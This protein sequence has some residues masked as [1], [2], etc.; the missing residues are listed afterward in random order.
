MENIKNKEPLLSLKKPFIKFSKIVLY[1]NKLLNKKYFVSKS[2]YD[3]FIIKNLIYDERNKVVSTFKEHLI[4]NDTSEFLRRYYSHKESLIRLK[5]YYE[6]YSKYSKLFPNYI[7]LSESKYIYK[8]IHKKQ[9]IIDI[10]QNNISFKKKDYRT[11]NNKPNNNKIFNS[12]VYE[13]IL[14]NSNNC[15]LDLFYTYYHEIDENNNDSISEIINIINSIDKY[16]MEFQNEYKYHN[17]DKKLKF[18][19]KYN[20]DLKNKNIIINNYY[21]NNSSILTKQSTIPSVFAQ[22][23]KNY[24][25][26]KILSILNSNLLIGLKK[27]KKKPDY[28][29][30]FN[31]STT[32]KNFIN[33]LLINNNDD[34]YINK[35]KKQ[36]NNE[37]NYSFFNSFKNNKSISNNINGS[38][39]YL[40]NNKSNSSNKNKKTNIFNNNIN[41]YIE[42]MP[43]T[44]RIYISQN[45]K[46]NNEMNRIKHLNVNSNYV[47]KNPIKKKSSINSLSGHLKKKKIKKIN[48]ALINRIILNKT[49]CL[50]DRTSHFFE[51]I[52]NNSKIKKHLH[53]GNIRIK[54]SSNNNTSRNNNNDN[55]KPKNYT[56]INKNKIILSKKTFRK[57]EATIKNTL[58]GLK[59]KN[60][61]KHLTCKFLNSNLKINNTNIVK[62]ISNK[63]IINNLNI[64]TERDHPKKKGSNELGINKINKIKRFFHEKLEK[65]RKNNTGIK[66]FDNN[67]CIN[68]IKN[69]KQKCNKSDLCTKSKMENS[70]MDFKK[71][72]VSNNKEKV[73]KNCYYTIENSIDNSDIGKDYNHKMNSS[74]KITN[75]NNYINIINQNEKNYYNIDVNNNHNEKSSVIKIKGIKIK[76]FNKILNINR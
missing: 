58:F 38:I 45:K 32:F 41:K 69:N 72:L 19:S 39:N 3:K 33:K 59:K 71:N 29:N 64:K 20:K 76:N 55:N 34:K 21:Y 5:K 16:E 70:L 31:N 28:K 17:N 53:S 56:K 36:C 25:N 30:N 7:P 61:L 18:F 37:S 73:I 24:T 42:A 49:N 15:I 23:Q 52:K 10:Q 67:K 66:Q 2:L 57:F 74:E 65:S 54:K 6:F 51:D 44:A 50:S 11:R 68:K 14:K 4:M 62:T 22:Q 26:E 47:K 35:K 63:K 48:L 13:S 12:E 43:K 75:S 1:V 60:N 27:K 46:N 40:N 9:K 8:N